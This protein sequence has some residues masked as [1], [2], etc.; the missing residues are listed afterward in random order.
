M[1][2]NWF[3]LL[4]FSAVLLVCLPSLLWEDSPQVCMSKQ[5]TQVHLK[6]Q[7]ALHESNLCFQLLVEIKSIALGTK[8]RRNYFVIL[9]NKHIPRF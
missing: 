8:H 1:N 2:V 9:F 3:L 6:V 4:L 7:R 5:D